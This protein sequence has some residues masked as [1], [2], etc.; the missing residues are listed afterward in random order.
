MK[1]TDPRT[2]SNLL[3]AVLVTQ[4]LGLCLLLWACLLTLS[5]APLALLGQAA[6]Q[7][8]CALVAL[9]LWGLAE[10]GRD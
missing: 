5:P 6:Y 2:Q 8:P 4:A 7:S 3:V 1:L 10:H 9:C